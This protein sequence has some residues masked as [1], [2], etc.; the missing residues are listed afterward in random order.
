MFYVQKKFF[1][2]LPFLGMFG[3]FELEPNEHFSPNMY[4]LSHIFIHAFFSL[5]HLNFI[6]TTN[7][8]CP[9]IVTYLYVYVYDNISKDNNSKFPKSPNLHS[10]RGFGNGV[11]SERTVLKILKR[12]CFIVFLWLALF[13]FLTWTEDINI[14]GTP[15][16]SGNLA[17]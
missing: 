2:F 14:K 12:K 6:H 3:P 17:K 1:S 5:F 4:F 15:S 11:K 7:L 13:L 8:S 9:S 10:Q 16:F